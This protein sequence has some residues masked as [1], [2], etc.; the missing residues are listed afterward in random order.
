[1]EINRIVYCDDAIT[2][3]NSS[4]IL[5]GCSLVASIPDFSEF[6]KLTLEEWKKWFFDTATL[7]MSKCPDDGVSIF[8][9]TDIKV[10]GTWID[11][12][13]ICQK[14]AEI[15]GFQLLW[16]KI[17]CR[18]P[19][20]TTLFGMPSY[21]RI[22]CFS[23]NLKCDISKST[24]DVIPAMGKKTWP[25][26]MGFE[27]TNM[28]AKFIATQTNSKTIIHPF[29]GEGSMLAAANSYGL[30]AVGIEKSPKRAEKSRRLEISKDQKIWYLIN[31]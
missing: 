4:P 2:W 28:I 10:E 29:C 5:T 6:P 9:Q 23:K 18:A 31:L 24:P 25:R 15:L 8:Y 7:V 1:M 21:T 12:G 16:H 17:I 14:A 30:K 20:G 3:L 26:G 13:F 11:K 27:A 22:L 19:A